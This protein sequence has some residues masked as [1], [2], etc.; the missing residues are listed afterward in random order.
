METHMSRAVKRV[1][2]IKH[3]LWRVK[4]GWIL[5]PEGDDGF[6][7]SEC[8]DE[9][10]V[11]RTLKEFADEYP[12]RERKRREKPVRKEVQQHAN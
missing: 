2:R 1:M 6:I 10:V 5:V 11:F 3:N 4:N 7:K 12:K 9:I 8:A